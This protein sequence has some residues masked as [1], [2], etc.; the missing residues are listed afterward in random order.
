LGVNTATITRFKR[1][2]NAENVDAF[3]IIRVDVM[4]HVT[5]E[6]K[7]V[8]SADVVREKTCEKKRNEGRVLCG[9]SR[10]SWLYSGILKILK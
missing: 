9:K 3:K 5:T 8:S 10:E 7:R 6:P 2:G 4:T 1:L